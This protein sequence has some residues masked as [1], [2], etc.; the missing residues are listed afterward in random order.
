MSIQACSLPENAILNKYN[1]GSKSAAVQAYTD[2]YTVRLKKSVVL[3]DFVLAFYT[4]PIFRLERV[5]LKY[6]AAKPS[7]DHQAKLVAN[8]LTDTFAAWHVEHRTGNQLLMCDFAERTRSWFMVTENTTNPGQTLLWFGSAVV[9][10]ENKK[11]G[12]Q[13]LS[14]GFN[15]LLGFHKLYS[16][17][18]LRSAKI[19]LEKLH[20]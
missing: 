13:E 6:L 2:C 5:I 4:T 16:R 20:K 12:K 17:I 10:R 1:A 19:R 18:L 7:T 14:S 15:I 3:S 8:G 11:T 9:S